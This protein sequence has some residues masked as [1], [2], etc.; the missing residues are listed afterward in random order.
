MAKEVGGNR[1]VDAPG[2]L[3]RAF[4]RFG[5]AGRNDGD[6]ELWIIDA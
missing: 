1:A 2:D 6:D 5:R 4:A 3:G